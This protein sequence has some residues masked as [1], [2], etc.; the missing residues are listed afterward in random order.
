MAD[1]I[2][3][4]EIRRDVQRQ[5][6]GTSLVRTEIRPTAQLLSRSIPRLMADFDTT[7]IT[8][9]EL[10][11]LT[12]AI[13]AEVKTEWGGMWDE[14]TTD[15]NTMAVIDGEAIT[16]TYN[17]VVPEAM[18][19]PASEAIERAAKSS[20]MTLTGQTVQAG[21]WAQFVAANTD[22][23]SKI[24]VGVVREGFNNSLPLNEIV[25]QLRGK[26]NRQTK[27]FV[28]GVINGT[29]RSRAESLARTGISH[30]AN[31]SRDQFANTNKDIIE[32][33]ILF[34]TLDNV[35]TTICFGRHLNE[36]KTGEKYPPLPFHY[37]ERSQYIFK[38]P[39][40]DP[41]NT[42][43]PAVG[44]QSGP[45]AEEEFNKRKS[46][47]DN[48]RANRAEKR[49][50]GETTPETKS[51]VT[52]RGRKDTDIFDVEQISAKKTSDSWLRDQPT[53]FVE[54]SL[55]KTRAKLF[56]DGDLHIDRFTDM[57]GRELTLDELKQT[58]AGSAAFKK[59]DK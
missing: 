55:G 9:T 15:L 32:S 59:A 7:D 27:Q 42:E 26:Y 49:A 46:R 54:S 25:Q 58:K 37:N 45:E 13:R 31:V 23:T 3:D 43:R 20:V 6:F 29:A 52:F 36:Y 30:Y 44:G 34:A 53:W 17:D 56:I 10:N 1:S 11:K 5:R 28:G 22:T 14:I 47:Q 51:K 39:G 21:T 8:N 41:L 33:R 40:F 50:D 12:A 19:A 18:V 2:L 35:T 48:L 4:A 16:E 24:V 57:T 38:T